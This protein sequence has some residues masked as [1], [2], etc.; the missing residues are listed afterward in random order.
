MRVNINYISQRKFVDVLTILLCNLLL[1][2]SIYG[3]DLLTGSYYKAYNNLNDKGVKRDTS[4]KVMTT[5]YV[6]LD[7]TQKIK[8][9]STSFETKTNRIHRIKNRI[10]KRLEHNEKVYYFKE[11]LDLV[12][13]TKSDP[14]IDMILSKHRNDVTGCQ[15]LQNL[16]NKE[17]LRRKF[18]CIFQYLENR[19]RRYILQKVLHIASRK[20][21]SN[22]LKEIGTKR[23][24]LK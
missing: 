2:Y 16:G 6:A 21:I 19:D 9:N 22:F 3:K 12:T 7:Y 17:K 11:M 4:H 15:K 23:P 20:D 1:C 18:N 13:Y 14:I 8:N 5:N 10:F 24:S